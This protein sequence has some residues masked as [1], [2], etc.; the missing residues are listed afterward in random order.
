MRV[1]SILD[2]SLV[3]IP[4]VP[5]TVIFTGGC[6]FNC[7][8]CQNASLIPLDSGEER[9]ISSIIQETR[10]FLSEGYCITG[11]E[12]TIHSSLPEL[13]KALRATGTKHINLNTQ[14]SV[15]GV[16]EKCIPYLDSVWFDLKAAPERYQQVTRTKKDPWPRVRASFERLLASE[17]QLW[18]RTTYVG[19]LN[20]PN[21]IAAIFR[22]LVEVGFKGEYLIQN[23][24][25]SEGVRPEEAEQLSKTNRTEIEEAI[26]EPPA[27]ISV[28]LDWR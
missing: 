17:V 24:I 12:P 21:D 5:A 9:T 8:Y 14:G 19:G 4:G 11:G 23:Y 10:G 27:G 25:P 20:N 13:L 15:P 2:I 16:L 18:P 3:D 1:S 7:P 26:A 22:F 6:N 28:R